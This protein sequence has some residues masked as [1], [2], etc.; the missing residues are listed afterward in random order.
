MGGT[1]GAPPP[2]AMPKKFH[3]IH[4]VF[5]P[6]YIFKGMLYGRFYQK[7]GVLIG[8]W[9]SYQGRL[10]KNLSILLSFQLGCKG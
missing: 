3:C 6:G 5:A 10:I 9:S 1:L 2:F 8:I 7:T 4:L